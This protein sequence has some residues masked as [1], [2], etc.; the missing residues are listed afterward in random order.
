[1]GRRVPLSVLA[2]LLSDLWGSRGPA[3]TLSCMFAGVLPDLSSGDAVLVDDSAEDVVA[4]DPLCRE[5]GGVQDV[6][7]DPKLQGAVQAFRFCCDAGASRRGIRHPSCLV[8]VAP[9]HACNL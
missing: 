2:W 7:R 9:E 3:Q 4:L 6:G 5:G 1:V 8:A